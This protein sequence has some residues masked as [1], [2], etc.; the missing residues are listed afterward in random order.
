MGPLVV[1]SH[2]RFPIA[3]MKYE[4]LRM[5]HGS[6]KET[7]SKRIF[8]A[9]KQNLGQGNIFISVC[10]SFFSQ[11]PGSVTMSLPTL[12]RTAHHPPP[13]V[14]PPVN[15]QAVRILLECF[16]VCDCDYCIIDTRTF[17]KALNRHQLQN[18][19]SQ[20]WTVHN[21]HT[22]VLLLSCHV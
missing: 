8:T 9:R 4:L 3:T 20:M 15:K 16:F 13:T 6:Q 12:S 5:V 10:D 22:F 1:Y 21:S 7:V 18:G 11:G 19:K 14:H 17:V 2:L